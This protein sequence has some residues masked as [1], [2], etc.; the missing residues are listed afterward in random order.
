MA[1]LQANKDLRVWVVGFEILG[2]RVGFDAGSEQKVE[3]QFVY[4]SYL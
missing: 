4:Y 3:N 2:F 1:C